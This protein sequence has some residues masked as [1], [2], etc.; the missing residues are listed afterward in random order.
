MDVAI[1]LAAVSLAD[2]DTDKL[3]AA[4]AAAKTAWS[5]ATVA[6]ML[7]TMR[8]FTRWLTRR[9]LLNVD[10]CDSEM[11][12][13][14]TRAQRRPR[15]VEEADV[16]A[17]V[18]AAQAVPAG[19]QQMF[20]PVRDVALLRFL[21][22]SGARAEE[23]CGAAIGE[24][25]RRPERPMALDAVPSN[26]PSDH[27]CEPRY[28]NCSERDPVARVHAGPTLNT[29]FVSSPRSSHCRPQQRLRLHHQRGRT[30]RI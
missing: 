16:E 17:M 23:V 27:N 28:G 19:R 29:A 26:Q 5:D 9:Q 6:R 4:V 10:P 13:V 3:V 18:A 25:D 20:W 12:R 1:D 11:L 21:A 30:V 2:L 14:S 22:G 7:S 15:A 24:I 8:G